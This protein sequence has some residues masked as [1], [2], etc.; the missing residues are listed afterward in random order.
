MLLFRNQSYQPSSMLR[1]PVAHLPYHSRH[2][3]ARSA[4]EWMPLA[5]NTAS[6]SAKSVKPRLHT[7]GV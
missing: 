7:V 6:G 5:W 1:W 4:S 2:L 3:S